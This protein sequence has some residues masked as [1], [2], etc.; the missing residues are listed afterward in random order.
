MKTT[1]S[2]VGTINT[3]CRELS[4]S[5]HIDTLILIFHGWNTTS[6]GIS[7]EPLLT[8]LSKELPSASIIAPDLPGMG[9][10]STPKT[11]WSV[12]EYVSWGHQ[13]YMKYANK[14]HKIIIVGHSFGGVIAAQL[15]ARNDININHLFLLAPAIIRDRKPRPLMVMQ[16]KA[17]L[18]KIVPHEIYNTIEMRWRNIVG[19]NDYKKT[20]AI[21]RKVF[22]NVVMQD[23]RQ[24]L[25][26]ILTPT[27]I[28]WGEKDTYTPPNQAEIIHSLI[29]HSKLI[30]LPNINHGIHL[31][32]QGEIIQELLDKNRQIL[33]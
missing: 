24:N 4:N 32:A 3:Y 28:L 16:V 19:S 7:W 11:V 20:D 10:S 31:H 17:G 8:K 25:P 18:K 9:K 1:I 21:M 2:E 15:A 5:L 23:T 14:N 33:E 12:E 13:M 29:P 27:T 6:G 26:N 22:T 30:I